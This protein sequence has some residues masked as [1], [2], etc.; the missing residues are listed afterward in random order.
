MDDNLNKYLF[1]AFLIGIVFNGIAIWLSCISDFPTLI[2]DF[3]NFIGIQLISCVITIKIMQ[4]FS[5]KDLDI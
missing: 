4:Y 1:I 5:E 2:R 3:V